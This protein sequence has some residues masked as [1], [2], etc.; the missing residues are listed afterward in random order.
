MEPM[1]PEEKLLFLLGLAVE[2]GELEFGQMRDQNSS[3]R[4]CNLTGNCFTKALGTMMTSWVVEDSRGASVR[5]WY[6]ECSPII[7]VEFISR[8][9]CP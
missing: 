6:G 3:A 9:R 4:C 8:G 7:M 2:P 5:R 1:S